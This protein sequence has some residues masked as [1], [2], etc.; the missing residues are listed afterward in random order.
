[1]VKETRKILKKLQGQ[2]HH[3]SLLDNRIGKL[4]LMPTMR[5]EFEK[6]RFAVDGESQI[7]VY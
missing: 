3:V 2:K 6:G 4:L 7:L 5:D 1:M